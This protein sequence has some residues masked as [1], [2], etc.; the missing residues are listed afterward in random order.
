MVREM[1]HF[2]YWERLRELG[3][4][5]EKQALVWPSCSLP[6]EAE[7][8]KEAWGDRTGG[9]WVIFEVSS[10]PVILDSEIPFNIVK[11]RASLGAVNGN[12][13]GARLDM[14]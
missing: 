2:C 4:S 9:N 11:H 5:G 14:G 7:R 1:G 3:L 8:W 6:V 13:A 10:N 12:G